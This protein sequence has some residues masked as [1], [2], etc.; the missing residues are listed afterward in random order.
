MAQTPKLIIVSQHS[1][2][3]SAVRL[4]KS[5]RTRSPDRVLRDEVISEGIFL[6]SNTMVKAWFSYR[7]RVMFGTWP[8][9]FWNM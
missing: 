3:A 4:V 8:S 2:A 9:A 6:M 5:T 1:V 7:K